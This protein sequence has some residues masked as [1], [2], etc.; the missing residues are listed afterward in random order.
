MS[1][2]NEGICLLSCI[3]IRKEPTSSSEM[4]SQLLFGEIYMMQEIS[5]GWANIICEYDGYEGWISKN[6]VSFLTEDFYWA[7]Y[8][9]RVQTEFLKPIEL[10]DGKII[11][12]MMGSNVKITD[13][14]VPLHLSSTPNNLI[15]AAH[16]FLNAPYLWGG[17]S[18][19][20]LDCSGFSQIVYKICGVKLL[21]DAYQQATQ[22]V[23]VDFIETAIPGDLA[24]FDNDEGKIT[25]V[26]I[27]YE[28]GKI[29]HSHG[30]V[31][32]DS[33]DQQGIF[34]HDLGQYTHKLRIVK[35]I[36]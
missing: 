24:F 18:L 31:R 23:T 13:K 21:R 20:G 15:A 32:I 22:G 35:R 28:P 27:I 7:K 30:F 26:G 8:K 9:Y 17:R 5:N 19:F 36:I 34:N 2:I 10:A 3:P 1:E 29:I 33:I 16:S 25:H 4:V 11:Q 6:Q 14:G 12:V